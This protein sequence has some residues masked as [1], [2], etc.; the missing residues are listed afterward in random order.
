M[1][2][3]QEKLKKYCTKDGDGDVCSSH[4]GC[5]PQADRND[6]WRC[7]CN[8]GWDGQYCDQK[9]CQPGEYFDLVA[10][11]C[12]PCRNCDSL[13]GYHCTPGPKS[14][15]GCDG[16]GT[17]NPLCKQ[18]CPK[19][20]YYENLTEYGNYDCKPCKWNNQNCSG[21]NRK[22]LGQCKGNQPADHT[23]CLPEELW[24][25]TSA[26]GTVK[27]YDHNPDQITGGKWNRHDWGKKYGISGR[28]YLGE[29]QG[30][31]PDQNEADWFCNDYGITSP[32]PLSW[33]DGGGWMDGSWA[34]GDTDGHQ[35]YPDGIG[36]MRRHSTTRGISSGT[37]LPLWDGTGSLG[38]SNHPDATKK[39]SPSESGQY[40]AAPNPFVPIKTWG[41][42]QGY[43]IKCK[44]RDAQCADM[45]AN[46][47]CPDLGRSTADAQLG[48][49]PPIQPWED[50]DPKD[51]N[52]TCVTGI[53]G[54][55]E[56]TAK[57]KR[58]RKIACDDRDT[59]QRQPL[60][61]A[62]P[63]GNVN[64]YDKRCPQGTPGCVERAIYDDDVQMLDPSSI[65]T[66]TSDSAADAGVR[67]AID[68]GACVTQS[69]QTRNNCNI[70]A[71]MGSN[72]TPLATRFTG[73]N[74]ALEKALACENGKN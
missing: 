51:Q 1:S 57:E 55:R 62:C 59:P 3:T 65:W 22:L 35:N 38:M 26:L 34:L 4:G 33:G 2:V 74:R 17:K 6:P 11:E 60:C 36:V 66:S 46:D 69:Y 28:E 42:T 14:I 54:A 9:T 7:Y 48:P 67:F 63:F 25:D 47:T 13:G 27:C 30:R 31:T 53:G 52:P 70:G 43:M 45:A 50:L 56:P 10:E 24:C 39:T 61:S 68:T 40:Q 37:S 32:N 16:K 49:I 15:N 12:K 73:G 21:G 18:W 44:L 29:G 19:D 8:P 58:D 5:G 72:T 64:N 41:I 20:H 71:H 23:K